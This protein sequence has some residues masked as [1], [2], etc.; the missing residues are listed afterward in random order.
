M[1]EPQ[2]LEAESEV[3]VSDL[4]AVKDVGRGVGR[5]VVGEDDLAFDSAITKELGT[6]RE[7]RL[8][9]ASLVPGR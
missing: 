2:H 1:R 8:D 6:T 5:A 3:R 9:S 7:A 4:R